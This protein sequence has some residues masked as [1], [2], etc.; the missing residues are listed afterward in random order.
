MNTAPGPADWPLASVIITTRGR[1]ELVRESIAAVVAQSY[2]GDIECIV[3]H[4]QEPPDESLRLLGTAQHSIRVAAN[5]CT[6]GEAGARNESGLAVFDLFRG[7]RDDAAAML[8][9]F[10]LLE[11]DG[12]DLRR[13]PIE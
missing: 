5:R 12:E 9:A 7:Y 13:T 3:V 11:L 1:P 8:C 4:D 10:D 2:P 6:P